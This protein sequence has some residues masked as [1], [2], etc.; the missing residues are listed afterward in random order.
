[1]HIDLTLR[2]AAPQP[3]SSDCWLGTREFPGYRAGNVVARLNDFNDFNALP[4]VYP[5]HCSFHAVL[6]GANGQLQ[7][8]H[9]GPCY[10]TA[11]QR[12]P[13]VRSSFVRVVAELLRHAPSE[14]RGFSTFGQALTFI[15]EQGVDHQPRPARC[16]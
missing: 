14:K 16:A 9:S 8:S 11:R 5:E 6:L 7:D 12:P 4:E 15:R 13:H 3:P 10:A 1:M 2:W